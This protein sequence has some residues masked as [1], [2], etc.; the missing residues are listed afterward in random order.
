MKKQFTLR[1]EEE[2]LKQ[3]AELA[4]KQSFECTASS[5]ARYIITEHL[6]KPTLTKEKKG[7]SKP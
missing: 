1:L 2:H 6:K 7:K 3:L 5:Y 4:K